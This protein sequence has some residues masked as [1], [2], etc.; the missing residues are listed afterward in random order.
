MEDPTQ[1]DYADL[2]ITKLVKFVGAND[3]QT[4]FENFFL[5]YSCEFTNDEEHQLRYY[6]LYEIFHAMFEEKLL[7]FCSQMKISE[8]EFFQRCKS[9]SRKDEKAAEYMDILLSSVEYDTFVKLMRIMRT[10]AE[11]RNAAK[12]DSKASEDRR[13]S[14]LAK[15]GGG[16]GEGSKRLSGGGPSSK[17]VQEKASKDVPDD[18]KRLHHRM[19][20]DEMDVDLD[21]DDKHVAGGDWV[22]DW[23]G[24]ASFK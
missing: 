14:E 5:R 13:E 19:E 2:F 7:L 3:F 1:V 18:R 20:D 10:V 17:G 11:R 8:A 22:E 24:K 12:A 16:M 4:Q 6:E 15:R 23:G 21:A 9:A